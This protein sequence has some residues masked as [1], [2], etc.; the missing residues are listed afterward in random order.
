MI[1]G[2]WDFGILGCWDFAMLGF[3]DVGMSGFYLFVLNVFI[4]MLSAAIGGSLSMSM[5]SIFLAGQM[6]IK[7]VSTDRNE[8]P[9]NS[10]R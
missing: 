9:T 7:V 2:F 8:Y 5:L 4:L 3:W 6:R 1:L 10:S